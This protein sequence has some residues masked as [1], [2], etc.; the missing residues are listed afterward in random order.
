MS[1]PPKERMT[2]WISGE[3]EPAKP[4]K[5][6]GGTLYAR[7]IRARSA[8]GNPKKT[9]KNPHFRSSYVE[10]PELEAAIREPLAAEGLAILQCVDWRDGTACL[11]SSLICEDGERLDLGSMPL[12]TVKPNDPQAL[13]S[14]ITYARRYALLAALGLAGEDDDGNQAS[15]GAHAPQ[16]PATQARPAAQPSEPM[17]DEKTIKSKFR[18]KCSAC[19]G[20]YEAGTDIKWR[21]GVNAAKHVDCSA[22][23]VE[24]D[25]DLP[26]WAGGE[27][28]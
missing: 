11:V 4:A 17:G 9:G 25:D 19:G 28:S 16:A 13:G 23:R 6:K 10:L 22:P 2:D 5:H 27:G 26:P 14:S 3:K 8:I 18:G 20:Y 21:K 15:S 12:L 1:E 7:L 24:S